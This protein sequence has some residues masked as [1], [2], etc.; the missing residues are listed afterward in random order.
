MQKVDLYVIRIDGDNNLVNSRPCY[1]CLQMM[2]AV[3]IHRVFYSI[4]N[5]IV[6][7]KVDCMVSINSSSINRHLE[8]LYYYA[9]SDRNTYY[10]N[11]LIKYMPKEI[12]K[13]NLEC[14][15]TYNF[16]I[17]LPEFK[18]KIN[19]NNITFYDNNNIQILS[20]III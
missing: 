12:N 2:K 11:L 19:N 20:S 18:W 1:N 13:Y 14:F 4:D 9:S 7:E 17:T 8:I 16:I 10:K 3:G 15:L 5:I 6:Y